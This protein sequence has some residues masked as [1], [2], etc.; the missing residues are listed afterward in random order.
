MSLKRSKMQRDSYV[1]YYSVCYVSY[2]QQYKER[3]N[4][5]HRDVH[6]TSSTVKHAGATRKLKKLLRELSDD[7][8]DTTSR[9]RDST[10]DPDTPNEDEAWLEDFNGYL[11][12]KDRLGEL[13]MV[14]WWGVSL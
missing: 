7:E 3:H 13:T 14:E 6:T 11:Q 8:D 2:T 9:S 10:D 1:I 5:M 12:S 4:Q